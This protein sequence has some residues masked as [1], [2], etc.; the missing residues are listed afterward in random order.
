LNSEGREP[1][2]F[3]DLAGNM[4]YTNPNAK[5]LRRILGLS[6]S[7]ERPAGVG[8]FALGWARTWGRE[9]QVKTI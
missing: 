5:P 8:L 9:D 6:R 3:G 1:G 2:G 7:G 4:T